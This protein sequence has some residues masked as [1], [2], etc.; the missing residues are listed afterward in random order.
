VWRAGGSYQLDPAGRQ[1]KGLRR[2]I[3]VEPSCLRNV[4]PS[5][6]RRA[7]TRVEWQEP[8]SQIDSPLRRFFAS[9]NKIILKKCLVCCRYVIADGD[10]RADRWKV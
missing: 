4:S 6:R 8:R 5:P 1:K 3:A 10:C 7:S 2:V 9:R